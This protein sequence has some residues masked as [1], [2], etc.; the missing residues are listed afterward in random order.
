MEL[1]IELPDYKKIASKVERNEV[2]VKEKEI[3]QALK[4]LQ[5]SR[6]KFTIK[7]APAQKGDF[8]EIEYW[9]SQEKQSRKDAFILGQG[10]FIPG[11]EEKI[12]GMRAGEEKEKVKLISVQN[13]EFPKINDEFAK[14]LGNF[15]S[16]ADFKKNIIQ[17]LTLEKEQTELQR[18][19]Q[20]ILENISKETK[21]EIPDILIENEKKH[22]L[23]NLKKIASEKELAKLKKD[24]EIEAEKRI[25][26]FLILQEID[27]RENIE[28]SDQ[29]VMQEVN[30]T[31]KHYPSVK[32]AEKS[33]GLDLQKFKEYTKQAIKTEKIFKLLE[34]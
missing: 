23:E 28:V 21:I 22:M 32:D 24:V 19:R 31:L 3:E 33:I 25:K 30:K 12:I 7:N 26:N 2:E 17:G 5:K 8:V 10:H 27:K 15:K 18:A 13:V 16:L 4:W 14:G 6:A 11:F 34:L 20:E 9:F 1:K 29:E